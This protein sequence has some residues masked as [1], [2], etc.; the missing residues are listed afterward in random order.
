[1]LPPLEL[2]VLFA[3][4]FTF[5][6]DRSL[7]SFFAAETFWSSTRIAILSWSN[8]GPWVDMPKETGSPNFSFD[9]PR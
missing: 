1:M 2:S 5:F 4:W 6:S 9:E 3:D 8:F 7:R